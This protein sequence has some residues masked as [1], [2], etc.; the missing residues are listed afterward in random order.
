MDDR[1]QVSCGRC[2]KRLLVRV[3]DIQHQRT[4]DCE[5]CAK[6]GPGAVLAI[7][8]AQRSTDN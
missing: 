2:G 3:Q 7:D 4:I 8:N 5:S 6:R 1:I